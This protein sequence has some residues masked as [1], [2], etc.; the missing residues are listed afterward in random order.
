VAEPTVGAS[1]PDEVVMRCAGCGKP[2]PD[3]AAW[4]RPATC[5][6]ESRWTS[7]LTFT[8]TLEGVV[9]TGD[10]RYGLEVPDA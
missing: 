1:A 8:E 7:S 10:V 2:K 9:V 3:D 4:A 6:G 5:C